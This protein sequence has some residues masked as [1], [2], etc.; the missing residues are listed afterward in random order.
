MVAAGGGV[1]TLFSGGTAY[2]SPDGRFIGGGGNTIHAY[3]G[4]QSIVQMVGTNAGVV[5]LFSGGTPYFSPDGRNLGGSGNTVHA[6]DGA[7]SIVQMQPYQGGV[8][9]LFSGRSVYFSPDGRY[10]GGGGATS[11][12]T[13]G[14][15]FW[16]ALFAQIEA[17]GPVSATELTFLRNLVAGADDITAPLRYLANKVVNGDPANAHF[18]RQ[19]LPANG[20]LSAGSPAWVLQDLVNKWF[21]GLDHPAVPL[22]V[23]YAPAPAGAGLFAG[24]VLKLP[25]YQDVHQGVAGDCWLLAALAE[26]AYRRPDLISTMFTDNGD[27][28]WTVRFFRNGGASYVTVDRM[29]PNGGNYYDEPVNGALWAA[30]AEKAYAQMV[31]SGSMGRGTGVDYFNSYGTLDGGYGYVALNQITGLGTS[32]AVASFAGA[33]NAANAG[34][35][36][37]LGTAANVPSRVILSNHSYAVLNY[38]AATG[39]LQVF[40][41]WGVNNG[42]DTGTISVSAA[43]FGIFFNTNYYG[44][45]VNTDSSWP[46]VAALDDGAVG[47][48][49][50]HGAWVGPHHK[51]ARS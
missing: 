48:D 26:V 16:I 12:L 2:F 4:S 25:S 32:A 8:L 3:D 35:L 38:N 33:V 36:V 37:V 45:A 17:N 18:Q 29:L 42:H 5:T 24:G 9:T 51:R 20:I 46:E 13:L 43:T 15:D 30:L 10:I 44:F 21:R 31:E 19:S 39:L 14:H 41:P 34:Q 11:R 27:G 49:L 28:T 23:S 47:G 1:D 6:Y 50:L 40:N 22:G 7:Q